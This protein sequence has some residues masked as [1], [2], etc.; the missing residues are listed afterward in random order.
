MSA[1]KESVVKRWMVGS[2]IVAAVAVGAFM[3]V[4]VPGTGQTTASYTPPRT[5]DGQ[6]DLQGVW[7]TLNTASWN[8]ED[9]QATLGVP[10]G[11]SVVEGGE[12][13]Y[14]PWALAKRK[15]NFEK[16]A[17]ADPQSRCYLPGVPRITYL[18][19][20][21]QIVQ[22]ADKVSILYEYSQIVRYL[23]MN[24]NPHPEGPIEWWMGDSRASWDG[25][26]LVVDVV[27][28]TPN[29]WLDHAGNFHS[30]AVHVVERYTPTGP[31]NMLYEAT[32]EDPKVFT[33]PWKMSMP[34]YRRQER[35]IELLEYECTAYLLE[36]EWGK[37]DSPL[38]K[39]Q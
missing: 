22:Q 26:T 25:N 31:D 8:L 5:P 1:A 37:E 39:L 30:E 18:P 36:G 4:G 17:T 35:N 32:I 3:L 34:L 15:E 38:F 21:F 14:Q 6:P 10:A 13:P 7:Q 27:H 28:F 9:H 2:V 19:Y 23:Y 33:R 24:G 12:I 20:P 29:T 11:Q 16:R